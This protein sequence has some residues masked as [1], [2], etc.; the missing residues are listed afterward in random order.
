MK[1]IYDAKHYQPETSVG[2]LLNRARAE[3]LSAIDR[4][5]EPLDVTAA[6]YAIL[7][8]VAHELADSPAGLCKG[9]AYDPGAMTRMIDRLEAKKL[10]RRLRSPHDRRAINLELTDEGRAIVPKLRIQVVGVIN[11]FLRGFTQSEARQFENFL[12]RMIR[13]A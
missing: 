8:Q 5:L 9:I 13:N 3:L 12:Q 6:Q 11:R 1:D 10:I 7:A 4:E 2:Y